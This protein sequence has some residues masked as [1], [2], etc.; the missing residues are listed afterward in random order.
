[1]TCVDGDNQWIWGGHLAFVDHVGSDLWLMGWK[2]WLWF[3]Q[4]LSQNPTRWH[5]KSQSIPCYS[6][7]SSL[8]MSRWW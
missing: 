6:I 7:P 1:L 2:N 4:D 5:P 3:A 8:D